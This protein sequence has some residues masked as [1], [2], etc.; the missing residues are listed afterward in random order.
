[1]RIVIRGELVALDDDAETLRDEDVHIDVLSND[2]WILSG[3]V[4][5]T[6][7]TGPTHGSLSVHGETNTI[8]WYQTQNAA[9]CR[10]AFSLIRLYST[11]R[12]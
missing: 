8:T 1:M 10:A 6:F 4:T 7:V 12:E 3:G 11:Y 2:S 9:R 5:I